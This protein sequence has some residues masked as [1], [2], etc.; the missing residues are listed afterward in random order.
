MNNYILTAA[1]I[2]F[3]CIV[4]SYD[5]NRYLKNNYS[6]DPKIKQFQAPFIGLIVVLVLLILALI[7]KE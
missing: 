7:T 5:T 2:T 4:V 1:I 6:D 3:F